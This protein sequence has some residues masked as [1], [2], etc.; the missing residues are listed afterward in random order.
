M[1]AYLLSDPSPSCCS[2]SVGSVSA[3]DSADDIDSSEPVV[4]GAG[5]ALPLPLILELSVVKGAGSSSSGEKRT[6]RGDV[7]VAITGVLG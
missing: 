7:S 5:R 2:R 3:G 1:S 6:A 4:T